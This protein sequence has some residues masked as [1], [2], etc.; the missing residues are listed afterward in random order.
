M[1]GEG[2]NPPLTYL[3]IAQKEKGE[4]LIMTFYSR[5]ATRI[6]GYDYASCN[7]YFLTICTHNRRCFFGKPGKLNGLGKVVE[8]HI[9][10]IPSHYKFVKIDKYVVMPNHIHMI[11]IIESQDEKKISTDQIVGQ[12]KA[13]VSREIHKFYPELQLWQR[14]FH[15]TIIRNQQ[16]YEKIWLY[17]EGNPQCWEKDCFYIDASILNR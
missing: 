15:D 1:V 13:G 3:H 5:K 11:L 6:P 2:F 12:F 9:L 17:I 16:I 14:S 8:K 10:K 4:N 7:Y